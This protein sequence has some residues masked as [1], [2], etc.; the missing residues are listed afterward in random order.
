[1]LD[2][3][4]IFGPT[5]QGEGQ[6]IGRPSVFIR[7]SKCNFTCSGFGVAY[8][9]AGGEKKFGCDT[10][11]AVDTAFKNTWKKYSTQEIINEVEK[12]CQNKPY[13]IVIS[14][15][16]PLLFWKKDE[17]QEILKYFISKKHTLTIETNASLPIEFKEEYQKNI[18]FS[19]SVKL[20]NS[21]EKFEKRINKQALNNILKH[22]K[23]SYF[24]F[25]VN[26]EHIKLLEKEIKEILA[27]FILPRVYIMPM[28]ASNEELNMNAQAAINLCINNDYIYSDRNHIRIWQDKRGV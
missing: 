11:Y 17:F 27:S 18:L 26:E 3:N 15:G 23:E 2:V 4:E 12:L 9:T 1:M 28:G 10:Y 14:G 20:S 25:V 16:E 24:K 22:S 6:R 13:D 5:I 7:F 21:H 8:T 19:M